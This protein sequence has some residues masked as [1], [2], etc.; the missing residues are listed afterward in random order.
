[1]RHAR[2]VL[3]VVLVAGL[4]GCGRHSEPSPLIASTCATVAPY[5][6]A[7]DDP[8]RVGARGVYGDSPDIVHGF[9][10]YESAW[11]TLVLSSDRGAV[12]ELRELGVAA[13]FESQLAEDPRAADPN[14][15]GL[16]SK[17]LSMR[18]LAAI[19]P[20]Y[21]LPLSQFDR[22]L[23]GDRYVEIDDVGNAVD[24]TS[25]VAEAYVAAGEDLPR[26]VVSAAQAR[27]M[28]MEG[29]SSTE[30]ILRDSIPLLFV[31]ALDASPSSAEREAL[32]TAYDDWLPVAQAESSGPVGLRS[33]YQ[34]ERV[35]S[36]L[37][38]AFPIPAATFASG[39]AAESGVDSSRGL[40]GNAYEPQSHYYALALDILPSDTVEY[41]ASRLLVP[42]GWLSTVSQP[43]LASTFHA[44]IIIAACGG[45]LSTSADQIQAWTAQ[46]DGNDASFR[47]RVQ[48]CVVGAVS[49]GR[50]PPQ[51]VKVCRPLLE[52]YAHELKASG[53]GSIMTDLGDSLFS[54]VTAS[55]F[56]EFKAR[57]GY[58]FSPG[59]VCDLASTSLVL[60]LTSASEHERKQAL[61]VFAAD[62][63]LWRLTEG[64]AGIS[65]LS[66]LFAVV[67]S[68]EDRSVARLAIAF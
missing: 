11:N 65:L 36:R 56:A 53:T 43:T 20:D 55:H 29:D 61:Q 59:T 6:T 46:V 17:A 54:D 67:A 66:L 14:L 32:V 28:A 60:G 52:Q 62:S 63:G 25:V 1:M 26:L 16:T 13:T 31:A 35:A 23:E 18:A 48:L 34:L 10:I 9:S 5:V 64:D 3:A 4:I 45:E 49:A 22:W 38:L 68:A 8:S 41:L 40:T 50:S 15:S 51:A 58:S 12:Q 42:G 44:S 47:E 39:L 19:E 27:V 33:L 2:L 37:G 30:V 57:L 7:L 24:M 21:E